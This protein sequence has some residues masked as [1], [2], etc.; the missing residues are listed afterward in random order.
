MQ[1]LENILYFPVCHSEVYIS[2]GLCDQ[3]DSLI[4]R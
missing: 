3:I 4:G 2:D 1:T